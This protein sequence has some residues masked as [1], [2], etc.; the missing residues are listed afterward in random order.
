MGEALHRRAKRG[1]RLA[2]NHV[3]FRNLID[4]IPLAAALIN[5]D[6]C[7]DF[8]NPAFVSIFGEFTSGTTLGQWIELSIGSPPEREA[9]RSLIDSNHQDSRAPDTSAR[10]VLVLCRNNCAKKVRLSL[11]PLTRGYRVLLCADGVGLGTENHSDVPPEEYYLGLLDN[12]T[13]FLYTLDL[14]GNV[15]NVNRA[16]VRT[17]G[18]EPE[19]VI[20]KSIQNII[21][22]SVRKHIR[23]NLLRVQLQG[24]GEG[25]SKYIGRDGAVHYL[26]YRSTL[27]HPHG[28]PP[29]IVGAARDITDRVV[30]KKAL[31]ESEAKFQFLVQHAHDG[32][33]YVNAQGII[34]F[35]NPRMREILKD[36]HP[37]GKPVATFYDEENRITVLEHLQARNKGA[38]S[39]YFVTL[40]DLEGSPHDMVVSG[41]P[42]FDE[43]NSY[44]GAIGIYTDITELKKLEA[45][46]QHSQKMEAV[47]TLAGGIAHDF[48]NLLSGVLG[49]ASLLQRSLPAGSKQIH[50][51]E[52][53][54]K[55]VERGAALA[56]QLLTFSRKRKE[57]V[58]SFNVHQVTS[59]LVEIL[60]RTLNRNIDV[61]FRKN[62]SVSVMQGDPGQLQQALM[63]L[64]INAADAMP[65][66]GEINISTQA[67]EVDDRAARLFD[68]LSPGT[69]VQ[70]SVEDDGEGMSDHVKSRIFEPFFTTKADGK[71]TGLGLSMVYSIVKSHGGHIRVYSELGKG[72]VFKLMFPISKDITIVT[73][74]ACRNRTPRASGTVLVADDEEV[75][76]SFLVEIL[77]DMG[78]CVLS[79]ENGHDAVE[80][81]RD[82]WKKIDLVILDLVMPKLNGTDALA[83]MKKVNPGVKAILT[84]GF[85]KE[86]EL[87]E[88][89]GVV[90]YLQKPYKVDELSQV[91]LSALSSES[92]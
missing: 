57:R 34:E 49:Y 83:E 39:T 82:N 24:F 73:E 78:F 70:I 42:Y 92:N 66:G 13:D 76:R 53:I 81:Y 89:E 31:R 68:G 77:E 48:N 43:R 26:E 75:I 84:T 21:P 54:E 27:V 62:A 12:L 65:Q 55:S 16:A 88:Q 91:V 64:C 9:L 35:C 5:P 17:L 60:R 10:D 44:R 90:G 63:N 40:T 51:A 11:L 86:H 58:C 74:K 85:S 18:Y 15:L 7:F 50:Y 80:I 61:R 20:G 23:E 28:Q 4:R 32:I 3:R 29:C 33:T 6:G 56:C 52:M 36:P 72:S 8:Q 46:L 22:P 71:G 25:I 59:E 47:G 14:D 67:L 79:S 45:Q 30:M 87:V 2:K 69:F 19:E 37:E 1:P 38:S 41:T